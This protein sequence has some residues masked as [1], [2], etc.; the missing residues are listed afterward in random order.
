[1]RVRSGAPWRVVERGRRALLL[2]VGTCLCVAIGLAVC[3]GGRVLSAQTVQPVYVQYEGFMR[4]SDGTMLVSFGYINL[5]DTDVVIPAG[6]KNY[7][8]PAPANRQQPLTF[9]KGPHRS[10]C[11]I[12]LPKDFTGVVR[13]S[14][15]HGH[16]VSVTTERALDPNY[17]LA[18]PTAERASAGV[19]WQ[20]A[21]RHV[22]LT[23]SGR[24]MAQK[25]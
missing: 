16:H 5:N 24:G 19:D 2:R 15:T 17:A 21:P 13:W 22:C 1:M 20:N 7:F 8:T 11:V 12:V 18:D 23:P 10:A 4:H 3:L 6:E 25:P 14:V 9:Q